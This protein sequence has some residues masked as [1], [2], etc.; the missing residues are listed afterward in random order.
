MTKKIW[1]IVLVKYF[2]FRFD[3]LSYP[4]HYTGWAW[5]SGTDS[6]FRAYERITP[7]LNRE[8]VPDHQAHPVQ[9][10]VVTGI[11]VTVTQ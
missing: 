1:Q 5:W 11:P 9:S 10:I 4:L 8:F 3:L 6:R 2:R 7:A